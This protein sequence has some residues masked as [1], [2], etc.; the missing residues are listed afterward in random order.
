MI[1]SLARKVAA[2]RATADWTVDCDEPSSTGRL[3]RRLDKC[4]Y[5]AKRVSSCLCIA[6]ISAE[7]ASGSG[8]DLP[9]SLTDYEDLQ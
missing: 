2:V 9:V 6:N 5:C 8:N 4:S 7:G 1:I 3:E